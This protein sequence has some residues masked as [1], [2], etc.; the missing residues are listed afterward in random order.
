VRRATREAPQRALRS[1][2]SAQ[3]VGHDLE[4]QEQGTVLVHLRLC[5]ETVNVGRANRLLLRAYLG[6]PATSR[7]SFR[8]RR[9]TGNGPRLQQYGQWSSPSAHISQI[10]IPPP[11]WQ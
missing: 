4:P 6:G 9:S 5:V 10:L 2:S 8:S 11:L 3:A 1:G 7:S